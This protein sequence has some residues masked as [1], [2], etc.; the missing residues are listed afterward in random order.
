M[1]VAAGLR[2]QPLTIQPRSIGRESEYKCF[3]WLHVCS[4][5]CGAT[6][7]FRLAPHWTRH[8]RPSGMLRSTDWWLGT[9]VSRQ[10]IGPILNCLTLEDV[11]PHI[12]RV[13]PVGPVVRAC[14][15]VS[16]LYVEKGFCRSTPSLLPSPSSSDSFKTNCEDP[17]FGSSVWRS[18]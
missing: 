10:P 5:K 2:P 18:C 11:L 13:P 12:Y 14:F 1:G 9:N 7:D 15:I 16:L 8:F 6:R 3:M 17:M 4:G